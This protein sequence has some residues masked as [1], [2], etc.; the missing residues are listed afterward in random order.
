MEKKSMNEII[1]IRML[2]VLGKLLDYVSLSDTFFFFF[3][4]NI[5]VEILKKKNVMNLAFQELYFTVKEA[6]P[7]DTVKYTHPEKQA[8]DQ[9][10]FR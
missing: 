5:S 4:N 3:A 9:L 10:K 7:P 6:K 2:C 1:C 8:C